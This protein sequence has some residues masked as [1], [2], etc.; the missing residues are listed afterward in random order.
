MSTVVGGKNRNG[1]IREQAFPGT[2]LPHGFWER[3]NKFEK[4]SLGDAEQQLESK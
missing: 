3:D 1:P 4:S 2:W